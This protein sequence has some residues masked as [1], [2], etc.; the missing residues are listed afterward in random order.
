VPDDEVFVR[1]E[2]HRLQRRFRP[3]RF[4]DIK[5]SADRPY[6]VKGILPRDGL[7]VVWGPPK[8]GKSFWVFDLLLHVALGWDYRGHRVQPGTVVYVACE[9]ERGLGA[10]AEAFRG[11]KL[12]DDSDPAF[13][14]LT[15]RLDLVADV[16][17][18]SADIRAQI[19]SSR[20]AAI[21]IDTLNRSI[22]GSESKDEDMGRYVKAADQLREDFAAAV[23]VI[24]HCGTNEN[25]PRGHTSLTGAADAQI[26]V[27]RDGFGHIV[28]TVEWLKDGAEGELIAS[29]LDV[30]E[31]G[32]DED[33]E[34]ITSCI[35]VEEAEGMVSLAQHRVKPLSAQQ[36]RALQMLARAIEIGGEV[37]PA[38]NHVPPG[39]RCVTESVWR[40]YTY[41]GAIS[42]GEQQAKR[43][44]FK[45]AAEV[46]VTLG[47]VGKWD[48]WVWIIDA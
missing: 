21:V 34:P 12:A 2:D 35:V 7:I 38:N 33:G 32:V 11:R 41:R 22:S 9:G 27:K 28:S 45:R 20:C 46:L 39:T 6:L 14:L 40:E 10:R 30:V 8:C 4:R 3:V 15:T 17:E 16:A 5:I 13:Y 31:V 36:G 48:P 42:D 44:A 47:R 24:H 1:Y 25:R 26:S 19:G 43:M 23:I 29:R 37:P 18:L